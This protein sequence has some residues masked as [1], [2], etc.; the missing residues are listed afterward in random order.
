M[1]IPSLPLSLCGRMTG[2]SGQ[3]SWWE[4]RRRKMIDEVRGTESVERTDMFLKI[5][6]YHREKLHCDLANGHNNCKESIEVWFSEWPH[7]EQIF[8]STF[9]H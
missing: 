2:R 7:A 6:C 9:L 5:N 3:L 4:R 1:N 8:A